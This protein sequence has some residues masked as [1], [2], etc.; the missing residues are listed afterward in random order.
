MRGRP[1]SNS[2]EAYGQLLKPTYEQVKK[3]FPDLTVVG[4]GGE[5]G[6]DC[7][8]NVVRSLSTAGGD[9]MDAWSIHPYRYPRSSER[10]KLVEEVREI[11]GRVG[12]AGA[13]QPVWITEIGWPTHRGSRG[14][15]ER[16]Q[17]RNCVRCLTLLQSTGIVQKVFW[18]D[19]KDDGTKRDYNEH[20]FGLIRHQTYHCAPKPAVVA[21]SV[22]IRLTGQAE[23]VDLEHDTGRY[24]ARYRCSDGTEVMIVWAES[25]A[26]QIAVS[27]RI[28]QRVDIMGVALQDSDMKKLTEDPVY[29]MGKNLKVRFP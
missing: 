26:G 21:L 11:A 7:A 20:N 4:I 14:S 13:T 2:P 18:Y 25:G 1:G 24:A 8:E 6:T 23:F 19:F 3:T 28:E 22:F 16:A 5:Y 9:S 12:E 10:S 27:G 17:A 15:S 29:L